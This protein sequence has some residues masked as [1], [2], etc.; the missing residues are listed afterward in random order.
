MKNLNG[1]KSTKHVHSFIDF[2]LGQQLRERRREVGLSL[3][4]LA[5][6]SG[7]SV[8][9]LSQVE[10]GITSASI[11]TLGRLASE[12]DISVNDLLGNLERRD[13]EANG[14]ISRARNHK[15][16]AM[17]DK[18]IV[19]EII[20]P[21]KAKGLDLY[22]VKLQPG[23][24]TGNDL[25]ITDGGDVA[26][27]VIYGSLELWIENQLILLEEGDSFCYPSSA[28]RKWGNPGDTETCVIWAITRAQD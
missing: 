25:F 18:K 13:D 19:K 23:G 7:L 21:E 1:G 10:R 27:C 6:R 26:G 2:W 28:R 5:A 16:L 15:R 17:K 8:G 4:S 11:K 9:T 14:W 24:S 3:Q 12:L 22:R 20:T